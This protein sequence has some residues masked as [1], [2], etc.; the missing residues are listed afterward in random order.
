MTGGGPDIFTYNLTIMMYQAMMGRNDYG[1]GSAVAVFIVVICVSLM[2]LI[3]RATRR[4]D[5]IYD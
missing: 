4:Y 3:N 5:M 1:Y 2:Y